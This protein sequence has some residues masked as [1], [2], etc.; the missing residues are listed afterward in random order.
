[1]AEMG[2]R[3]VE[4]LEGDYIDDKLSRVVEVRKLIGSAD[5]QIDISLLNCQD[6]MTAIINHLDKCADEEMQYELTW[7][8]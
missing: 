3:M 8:L 2:R 5:L 6:L 4:G 7:I 1:M